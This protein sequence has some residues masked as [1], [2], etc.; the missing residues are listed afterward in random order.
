[1][2][3]KFNILGL[4]LAMVMAFNGLTYAQKKTVTA[5]KSTATVV[6]KTEGSIIPND[7]DV[8]IGK[9]SNGLTYY[10]RKNVEPK[11]RAELYLA[12]R[13]G[14]LMEDDDQQGLAHFTEHMS[15]N[16]T[17]DFPKNEMINY[18]QKAGVRFGADLN[19]YT[20]FEQT[21]YQLPIPTDSATVFKTGFKIL[22]N[23]AGK[24]VMED[25][26]IDKERGVI[27]EEDRQRG[28]NLQERMSKQL[29]PLLLKDSRYE[30]RLPIGKIDILKSF[31]YDRIR[32]FYRD[33]YR[34]NLQAVIAVGDFDVNEVEQLI[35]ASFSDLTNPP[36]PRPRL[37]YDLPD[38]KEPL[39][40]IITDPE[41]THNVAIIM[42]KQ[43]SG[44]TRTTADFKKSLMY[45]MIN[46][47][48][49]S[50]LQE[51][52][53]KGD[54]PFIFAQSNYGPYQG[55]MVSGINA[56]Q[57]IVASTSGATLQK[58]FEAGIAENER[59]NKF[60]FVAAE[61]EM[62]KK[63]ILAGS[64]KQFK[65]KDKTPSSNFVQQYLGNFLNGSIIPSID[66]RYTETKKAIANITLEEVNA[67]AKTLT[68]NE[69]QIIIVQAPEK[70]KAELPTEAQ[71]IATLKNAGSGITAYVD[72]SLNKPLLDKKPAAGKIIKETKIDAIDATE[73]TLSNGIKVLL[74]KTDFKND[75]IIFSSFAKGGTSVASDAD[76]K[77]AQMV[78]LI[79]QNGV[80]EFNPTQL[81][82]LLAGNTGRAGTYIGDL[83]QGFSGS[84]SPKDLET[85]FQ[86]AYAYATN[87][88]KD[89]EI[90]NKKIS[91]I[92]VGMANK[93]ANPSSVF[94]DTTQA[95]LSSYHK[96]AMPFNLEDLDMVSLDKAFDFYKA[97]FADAGDQTF[98][99][100]G[101]F[102]INTIK[103]LIETYIASLPSANKKQNYVDAGIR[104]PKGKVSK[105]VYKG[106][107][108]KAS[109]ELF[110]HGDYDFSPESNVQLEALKTA[111]EIKLLERLREKE[112]GVYSPS[113]R[114]SVEKHPAAH[115]Y[116]SISFSC[117]PANVEK[118]IAASLD[119]VNKI[120]ESG[121]SPDDISKFKS[122]EQ[123]QLELNLRNNN[124]WLN[125]ITGC[126]QNEEDL[127]QLL[128][129]K[130]RL[131]D[132]SVES[133]RIAA[134][135][136][137][138][139]DNYIRLVLMPEKK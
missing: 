24:V 104:S 108:D 59:V 4:G 92:K 128:T 84:A 97:R 20:G 115:Y 26:E 119:E 112:S 29:L 85:S 50:R 51:M 130:Q 58:A 68:N 55:G 96:R 19:A 2:N 60:G 126:L 53:Q 74:K 42:Y 129:A 136:Y 111:L 95:V 102:D 28:K 33:W 57:T 12:T 41:Q 80:G 11:N 3:K 62:V 31:E 114:L 86:L 39:V 107:E 18:L 109:V 117:S 127:G 138:S 13:I 46:S 16:G 135:K 65:E 77:S 7:P 132:I 124:Y 70:D 75:Q 98:V 35:K 118:L 36:N 121:A 40:K 23:W 94:S 78:G 21:V 133:T 106:L 5:K 69:N 99:I 25:E 6:E 71:L 103:P 131:D 61:L 125:Y 52:L 37:K 137:L 90:F 139:D 14:S 81:N 105:T 91:D 113:I 93:N 67:L 83:Y 100:V 64:E 10:I 22:A 79:A 116:F 56:F 32:S 48:L 123:R 49:G 47:M 66:F 34:P 8:K 27:I 63:N 43:R 30:N 72:N 110:I 1:M 122:E 15:F 38:N 44:V 120:K 9:L 82:K 87:P 134:Q 88:R 76:F 101:N 17:K 54:A 89:S 45:S 73:F